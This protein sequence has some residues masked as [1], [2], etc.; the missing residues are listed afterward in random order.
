MRAAAN[1][2]LAAVIAAFPAAAA[3]QWR[4]RPMVVPTPP[5]AEVLAGRFSAPAAGGDELLVV[6]RASGAA[7]LHAWRA[8]LS[9]ASWPYVYPAQTPL[10]AGRMRESAFDLLA[11]VAY[12]EGERVQ[13]RFGANPGTPVTPSF[14]S[15]SVRGASFV[16]AMPHGADTLVFRWVAAAGG[17]PRIDLVDFD[18]VVGLQAHRWAAPLEATEDELLGIR[19]SAA[20][21]AL[22]V[23]DIAVPAVGGV[24]LLVHRPATADLL[25]AALPVNPW[26]LAF[27]PVA[28]GGA[29]A[30]D[31]PP[32]LPPT[33]P[34]KGDALGAAALDVDGDG[35][36]DLVFS[37]GSALGVPG[38]PG[39]APGRLVA[40]RSTGD[41]LDLAWPAG[42]WEDVTG[43]AD[44]QPLQDPVTLRQVRVNGAP[45]VAVWDRTLDEVIVI[46]REAGGGGLRT[47]RGSAEGRT[48]RDIRTA[49]VA[50]SPS[51]DLVVIAEDVLVFPDVGDGS[52]TVSWSP[53][54]PG[55]PVRGSDL[56][57]SVSAGDPDG[58][59]TVEWFV[60]DAHGTPVATSALPAGPPQ[61]VAYV[62]PA[63]ALCGAAPQSLAVTV[64]ATDALGVYDEV[65]AALDVEFPLP[66]LALSPAGALRL[67]P[68]GT[69][70]ALDGSHPGGCGPA[71]TFVWGGTLFD[72]VAPSQETSTATTTRRTVDLPEP[73]YAALL[74]L[75]AP[76]VT[77]AAVDGGAESPAASLAL[78][79]D[80]GG[81]VEVEHRSDVAALSTGEVAVLRTVLRSRLS[82]PLPGPRV[83]DVL[84]G[85]APAGPAVV[86]GA[87]VESASGGEVV[88][89][90]LPASGAEVTIDLP[91]RSTGGRGASSVEV[92]SSAGHLLTP[93]AP[94]AGAIP[95]PG[96]GCGSPGAGAWLALLALVPL[97]RPRSTRRPGRRIT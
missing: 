8:L 47:W 91:V 30:E 84:E 15:I 59:V 55:A 81:L 48:V 12:P 67:P 77:L 14:Q 92:R 11:D 20:A 27:E 31:R 2:F 22:G 94:R 89:V 72:A 16:R 37:Y 54:S 74:A 41:P 25:Y 60:G 35:R 34:R 64:R 68:G 79:L 23:D 49:D 52:P 24:F 97:A 57:M 7:R 18:P 70:V 9:T 39:F 36:P 71:V 3:A 17:N 13:L 53:G 78:S 76:D 58:P 51:P 29:S 50:G 44:L 61:P 40:V 21:V 43:R 75:P 42:V 83:I 85:L 90:E 63:A 10:R 82:V 45:A 56:P 4:A 96:C 28:V 86:S 87:A 62:R 65:S 46:S 73:A 80:A 66:A 93:P 5:G 6:D 26:D 33:V 19:V 69:S 32:W 95:L 1:A 38:Q 88:L